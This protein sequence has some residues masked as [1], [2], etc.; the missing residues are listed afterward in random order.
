[1]EV[2]GQCFLT[3]IFEIMK[4]FI[5]FTIVL[6]KGD[7]TTDSFADTKTSRTYVGQIQR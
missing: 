1:M 6:L 4:H 5:L 7:R 3:A 2:F